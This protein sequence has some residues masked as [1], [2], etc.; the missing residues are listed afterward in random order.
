MD[1]ITQFLQ[2]PQAIFF[3]V[4]VIFWKGWALWQAARNEQKIWFGAILVVNSVGLLE[5]VYL[6]FFQKEGR[7]WEKIFVKKNKKK[8]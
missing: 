6:L 7:L 4:W 3:F 2:S 8:K 1:Q 5:I